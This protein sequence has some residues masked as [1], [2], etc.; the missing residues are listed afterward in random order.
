MPLFT[1][2]D[3]SI[4]FIHIPKAAGTY[5]ENIFL[6]NGWK[7]GFFFNDHVQTMPK[8]PCTPQHFDYLKLKKYINIDDIP[9]F[10]ICRNPINRFKS[11]MNMFYD[12]LSNNLEN[13]ANKILDIYEK[14]P[15]VMDNH[16]RP[17]NEFIAKNTKIFYFEKDLSNIVNMINDNFDLNLSGDDI[18]KFIV[19]NEKTKIKTKDIVFSKE[20]EKRLREFYKKD[21]EYF[22]YE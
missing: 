19:L 2:E 17:Q 9:N 21:F 15:Y 13:N 22:G 1:K 8:D 18:K 10:A 16:I 14:D 5:V 7:I 20:L 12:Y 11:E 6:S 4:F 3:K